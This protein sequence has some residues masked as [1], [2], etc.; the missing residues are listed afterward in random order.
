MRCDLPLTHL[1]RG[2][3]R[4]CDLGAVG[5]LS[6]SF[7]RPGRLGRTRTRP[8]NFFQAALHSAESLSHVSES[9]CRND[10]HAPC[11]HSST[12]RLTVTDS[13]I[14]SRFPAT[15]TVRASSIRPPKVDKKIQL[16]CP[17][18]PCYCRFSK[19]LQSVFSR[20]S[21]S[22]VMNFNTI[23]EGLPGQ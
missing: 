17:A 4:E 18:E 3:S 2:P 11:T 19:Q 21:R 13:R 22:F 7:A 23:C 12:H 1:H 5:S 10:R 9:N 14:R 6:P 20:L 15:S 8:M 16:A